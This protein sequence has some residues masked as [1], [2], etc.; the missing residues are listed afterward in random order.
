MRTSQD[1]KK[2]SPPRSD[3]AKTLELPLLLADE[4]EW[5]GH[6]GALQLTL[7]PGTGRVTVH[8]ALG[9]AARQAV[10]IAVAAVL[11]REL[12]R[13]DVTLAL[14]AP[15][16][17]PAHVIDGDSLG[18]P[19]A[20]A[21]R[22]A[23]RGIAVPP[24]LGFTGRVDPAGRA[25]PVGGMRLKSEAAAA[26]GLSRLI[27]GA[28]CEQGGALPQE[29]VST[30][31]E[32]WERLWPAP[33]RRP[34][35]RAA[36][37]IALLSLGPIL[38][39]SGLSEPLDNGLSQGTL[40]VVAAPLPARE[41]AV[42]ALPELERSPDGVWR[43]FRDRR[44]RLAPLV[45]ALVAAGARSLSFDLALH[46][47]DAADEALA[48]ALRRAVS[49]RVP[50]VLAL[51]WVDGQGPLLPATEPLARLISEGVA[52]AAHAQGEAESG[53][54]LD[55]GRVR[56]RAWANGWIWHAAVETVASWSPGVGAPR[57]E[58][59]PLGRDTLVIGPLRAQ[60]PSGRL[61]LR[62][63]EPS[64]C[65]LWV[66]PGWTPSPTPGCTPSS[67]PGAAGE[68]RGRAVWIGVRGADDTFTLLGAP[69]AGVDVQ[70][71]ATEVLAAGAAPRRLGPWPD[72]VLAGLAAPLLALGR[73]SLRPGLAATVALVAAPLLALAGSAA[74]GW[75]VAPLPLLL[76]AAAGLWLRGRNSQAN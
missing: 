70:A 42:L 65:W 60:A 14:R 24:G 12:A 69:V 8:V 74:L 1:P 6:V 46:R 76:G 56:L 62:P 64:P 36:R 41:T 58:E 22:A 10:E 27:A 35:R 39:L 71:A 32:L 61:S 26:T 5:R 20:V 4:D 37:V 2:V 16:G 54:A 13:W 25:G 21:C 33:P 59:G 52:R 44:E 73:W 67:E 51:R 17:L 34:L 40:R 28:G 45:D 53:R 29:E 49:A 43:S 15:D 30:L 66:E 7:L 75:L 50:V 55:P 47:A 23:W 19:V 18:L 38:A 57:L 63:V 9:A 31:A 11:G 3:S 68:L 72:A 48:E